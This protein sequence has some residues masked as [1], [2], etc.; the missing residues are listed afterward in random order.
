MKF[1][2]PTTTDPAAGP[3]LP[4]SK[5]PVTAAAPTARTMAARPGRGLFSTVASRP[6][7]R[8]ARSAAG[9]APARMSR[10]SRVVSPRNT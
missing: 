10:V 8:R 1:F 6:S 4:A 5:A 2:E 3:V 9:I 7:T